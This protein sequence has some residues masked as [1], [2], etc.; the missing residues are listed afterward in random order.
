MIVI[1]SGPMSSR[2]AQQ[3]NC[4]HQCILFCNDSRALV[5]TC[6][7]SSVT[8][9]AARSACGAAQHTY[10]PTCGTAQHIWKNAQNCTERLPTA[11][12]D[13]F[14]RT[15]Q[16]PIFSDKG[17]HRGVKI[18][19]CRP[20]YKFYARIFATLGA[21]SPHHHRRCADV[22][23]ARHRPDSRRASC[24]GVLLLWNTL[25]A[26]NL[27]DRVNFLFVCA[28]RLRRSTPHTVLSLAGEWESSLKV[29][30]FGA[31]SAPIIDIYAG[32]HAKDSCNRCS[33][34]IKGQFG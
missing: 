10:S 24:G 13:L 15:F 8:N 27:S 12:Y 33:P 23:I 20:K 4:C 9:C 3:H 34:E 5:K 6:I 22:H 17:L 25:L 2:V 11:E 16:L 7:A 1:S 14:W 31:I 30:F 26:G 29:H 28:L 32:R 19:V 21:T 18:Y